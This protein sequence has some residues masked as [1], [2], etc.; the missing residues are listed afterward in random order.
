MNMDSANFNPSD[1]VVVFTDGSC[2][3]KDRVGGWGWVAIDCARV[4]RSKSGGVLDTTIGRMELQ[5]P[6]EAL[7]WLYD[8]HGP[9]HVAIYSD[10]EYVVK[11]ANDPTRSRLKNPKYWKRLDK[12]A[13]MHKTVEW[14][15]VKGHSN[16]QHNER[17]DKLAREARKGML[18]PK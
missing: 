14:T 13:S 1:G 15:H 17:A 11:G 6:T 5:A 7:T 4:K 12:A 2:Y 3:H 10:A 8:N 9:C 18:C 16:N